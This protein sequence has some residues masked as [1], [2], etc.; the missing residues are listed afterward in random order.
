MTYGGGEVLL[1]NLAKELATR[2]HEVHVITQRVRHQRDS[3]VVCGVNIWRVGLPVEYSG[4]LTTRLL[5]SFAYLVGAL[6]M[7][8]R[9]AAQR[10]VDIIHSNTYVPV[11]VGQTC[12]SIL[13][14]KHVMTVHDVYLLAMPWFWRK[15]SQQPDVSIVARLFGPMIE[16]MLLRV[17]ATAIHTVS[18]TSRRDLIQAGTKKP[19]SVVPNGINSF[20]YEKEP[21]VV[22]DAH[23]AIF[24]GRLVFYKNLETILTAFHNVT[25]TVLDARLVIVGDGPMKKRWQERANQLGLQ[26]HVKFCGLVSHQEKVHLLNQSAFLVLPSMVEGFG[27]VVLE[28]FACRKP[29]IVSSIAA[30]REIVTDEIDG[31]VEETLAIDEWTRGILRLFSN[32]HR[33]IQMGE[34]GY[35]KLVERYETNLLA[36][37]MENMYQ[38]LLRQA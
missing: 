19:I 31:F 3:E 13:R 9:V 22:T 2:G 28:A 29:V 35:V 11:L 24:I 38:S 20:D 12:A 25:K 32:P 8:L 36:V 18:E 37:A 23:Q 27:I 10:H 21:V 4:A 1:W 26:N 33:A 15:W 17:P 30:L 16:R 5:E 34:N 14:K 6:F 7:G